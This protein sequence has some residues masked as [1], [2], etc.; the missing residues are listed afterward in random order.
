[1]FHVEHLILTGHKMINM[2]IIYQ[3]NRLPWYLIDYSQQSIDKFIFLFLNINNKLYHLEV[4]HIRFKYEHRWSWYQNSYPQRKFQR[5]QSTP[6]NS[7][8]NISTYNEKIAI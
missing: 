6:Q 8:M 4:R 2:K 5:Q 3:K 7:K 1:M